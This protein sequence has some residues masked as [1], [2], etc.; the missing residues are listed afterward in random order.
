MLADNLDER[1]VRLRAGLQRAVRRIC[2]GWL[3]GRADD[4]VQ[5][6][7]LRVLEVERR[8]EGKVEFSSFYLTRAAHS[9]LVDELRKLRRRREVSLEVDGQVPG[10][11]DPGADPERYSRAQ[12]VGTAIHGCLQ[13]LL[14]SRRRATTLFL[15]GHSVPET[16]RLVGWSAKKTENLVYRGLADLRECLKARGIEP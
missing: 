16:G 11:I 10:P 15:Q 12:E 13:L 14:R 2:P 3:A 9:A 4:L 8:A 7:L 6:A 1:Y 5:V